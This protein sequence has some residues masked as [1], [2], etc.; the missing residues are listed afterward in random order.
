V[1]VLD[2]DLLSVVQR[3]DGQSY[4]ILARRLDS[5]DDEVAVSIISFEEQ[6]RGW[7]AYIASAKTSEEQV[8]GYR[9]LHALLDDFATRPVLDFDERA[10]KVYAELIRGRVRI[11]T[12][13]LKIS[14][15]AKAH[16]ALLLT[17]NLKDF[18]KVP[19]LRVEDWS[20]QTL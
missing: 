12:M 14:A 15:I 20:V 3:A 18:R 11:G 1:I 4:E 10:A 6:M 8:E 16:G 7:L 13:D 9:Y 17:R 2:T 19:G 5:A